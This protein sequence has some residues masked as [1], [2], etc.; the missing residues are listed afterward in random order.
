[1]K[2]TSIGIVA[3]IVVVIIG[4]AYFLY[5]GYKAPSPAVYTTTATTTQPSS[6]TAST[7]IASNAT[8]VQKFTV[9]ETEFGISPSVIPVKAGSTVTINVKN[10]GTVSH[11]LVIQGTSV[12]T[13]PIAPGGNVTVTFTAPAA[14]SYQYYCNI[15]GHKGLGMVGALTAS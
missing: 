10:A 4:A 9:T 7:T 14:G 3:A 11:D 12:S 13:P 5:Q 8:G 6:T 2:T 1:M 15:D